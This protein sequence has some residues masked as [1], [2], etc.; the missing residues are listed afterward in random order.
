MPDISLQ[1]LRKSPDFTSLSPQNQQKVE[2]QYTKEAWEET[3]RSPN[4]VTGGEAARQKAR[5]VF[6][7][8]YPKAPATHA[9][10]D[11]AANTFFGNMVEMARQGALD[12]IDAVRSADDAMHGR[13]G[14]DLASRIARSE[15]R[16]QAAFT[17]ME[18]KEA[19]SHIAAESKAW[20]S[21]D[22]FAEKL[23]AAMDTTI[24]TG[25]EVLNNPK[26]VAYLFAK[27]SANMIPSMF[28]MAAGSAAGTGGSAVGSFAGSF[29]TEAGGYLMDQVSQEVYRRGLEPTEANILTVLEDPKFIAEASSKAQ[30]K[31]L[32]T[33]AVDAGL[34]FGVGRMGSATAR[35]AEQSAEQTLRNLA[36]GSKKVVAEIVSE[37]V[38]EAAGQLLAEGK[39]D[40][41][42]LMAETLGAIGGGAVI[43]APAHTAAYGKKTA[44]KALRPKTESEM[45]AQRMAKAP[46]AKGYKKTVETAVE[47]GEIDES[48]AKSNPIMA[49]EVK[50]KI[51]QKPDVSPVE[52]IRNQEQVQTIYDNLTEKKKVIL[53]EANELNAKKDTINEDEYAK[54]QSL[55]S[56]AKSVTKTIK[57][58]KPLL[59]SMQLGEVDTDETLTQVRDALK[60]DDSQAV[61][62]SII[63]LFG[64]RRSQDLQDLDTIL[65]NPQIS[66]ST[67]DQVRQVQAYQKAEEELIQVQDRGEGKRPEEVHSNIIDGGPGFKGTKTY[68]QAIGVA[69]KTGNTAVAQEQ[70]EGLKTFADRHAAKLE[71]ITAPGAVQANG[72]PHAPYFISLV[73][74]EVKTLQEAVTMA[75]SWMAPTPA[76]DT[77]SGTTAEETQVADVAPAEEAPVVDEK[78][79]TRSVDAEGVDTL[80]EETKTEEKTDA[81]KDQITQAADESVTED[82]ITQ[83]PKEPEA[84][85]E[86]VIQEPVSEEENEG[87]VAART[88]DVQDDQA[89]EE[90]VSSLQS[91]VTTPT[92]A[93]PDNH[94]KKTLAPKKG[95][96]G[97]IHK[98]DKIF[99]ALDEFATDDASTAM[100]SSIKEFGKDFHGHF[101]K[102]FK[103]KKNKAF[104]FEDPIQYL[105]DDNGKMP[106]AV[107]NTIMAV[108][109][110][111]LGTRASETVHNYDDDLRSI[112]GLDDEHPLNFLA[113]NLLGDIGVTATMLQESLGQEIFQLLGVKVTDDTEADFQNK[114]E[115]SLGLQA[116]ATLESMGYLEHTKVLKSDFDALI[117]SQKEADL[118]S[119]MAMAETFKRDPKAKDYREIKGVGTI[120][121]YKVLTADDKFDPELFTKVSEPQKEAKGLWSQ[122]FTGERDKRNYSWDAVAPKGD[123]L[124]KGTSFTASEKQMENIKNHMARPR[125]VSK[126]SMAIFLMMGEENLKKIQGWVDP[127]LTHVDDIET[128]EG[129]NAGIE[130]GNAFIDEWLA[131]AEAR[132]EG[133]ESEFYVPEEFWRQGR[134]GEVG[135]INMQGNKTHRFLFNLTEWERELDITDIDVQDQFMEAV[136]LGL[137][138][139]T[140][141][142]GGM[143]QTLAKARAEL[144]K[145]VLANAVAAAQRV[146]AFH[147]GLN[148]LHP[149]IMRDMVDDHKEDMALITEGAL[150]GGMG[151]HSVKTILEYA[152][153]LNA[154]AAGDKT[155]TTDLATEIDGVSNG[156][157]IGRTQLMGPGANMPETLTA[158]QN[159]GFAFSK[160]QPGLAEHLA[161][162]LSHDAYQAT[163]F[164]WTEALVNKEKELMDRIANA[165]TGR[166]K[167]IAQGEYVQ[168]EA[169]KHLLGEFRDED[170]HISK[171]VRKVS[172]DPTMRT[173]YG[174]GETALLVEL[175]NSVQEIIKKKITAIAQ[176]AN[177]EKALTDLRALAKDLKDLA[178]VHVFGSDAVTDGVVNPKVLLNTELPLDLLN[179][180]Q[181]NLADYHG[182]ALKEAITQ[183]YGPMQDSFKPLNK[184][185][186]LAAAAYNTIRK[187]KIRE[188]AKQGPITVGKMREIDA[189]L[190]G[191][192]PRVRTYLGGEIPLAK[193]SKEK[194]YSIRAKGVVN[195]EVKQ[196]YNDLPGKKA[197]PYKKEGLDA[198]GVAGTI[199]TIHNQD[200]M[201]AN[202][203]M[204][205]FPIL[206]NH[207]GFTIG[208]GQARDLSTH[209]CE[210]FFNVM[211]DYD[212]GMELH[213]GVE[214]V[215]AE[216]A[217]QQEVLKAAGVRQGFIDQAMVEQLKVMKIRSM[218]SPD[219]GKAKPISVANYQQAMKQIM[220]DMKEV[221]VV[222]KTNK[223]IIMDATVSVEQYS[224]PGG[225]YVTGNKAKTIKHNGQEYNPRT[226]TEEAEKRLTESMDNTNEVADAIGTLMVQENLDVAEVED[227]YTDEDLP[228]GDVFMSGPAKLSVDPVEYAIRQEVDSMN[229]MDVYDHIKNNSDVVD[230]AE[231]DTHLKG[232]LRDVVQN[233]LRPMDL[234]LK[235]NPDLE[236]EGAF[237]H[238]G[239]EKD[240]V[241]ITNQNRVIGP[242]SGAL[243]QGLRMSTG[244]VY[245]HELL[246]SVLHTGLSMNS[247]YKT[248]VEQLFKLAEKKIGA[249]HFLDDPTIDMTDPAY[250]YEVE[251]AQERYD[252]VFRNTDTLDSDRRSTHLDEFMVLALTN[253]NF[254]N[255]L[256]D[257]ELIGTEYTKHSWQGLIGKNIQETLNNIGQAIM[258]FFYRR[259]TAGSAR[260]TMADELRDLAVVIAKRDTDQ[261][262]AL[263]NSMVQLGKGSQRWSGYCNMFIKKALSKT[264]ILKV[265]HGL[266]T[267][268][269]M[270]HESDTLLGQR[271]REAEYA[272]RQLDQGIIKSLLAE[273]RGRTD[274]LAWLYDMLGRRQL[275]LDSAKEQET[276]RYINMAS[277]LFT[278]LKD[279]E[280][281]TQPITDYQKTVATKVGLKADLS[282][283]LNSLGSEGLR[284]V[285]EDS[286]EL[287]AQV[288][289]VLD[290]I[291]ADADLAPYEHYYRKAADALGHFMIHARGRR[292]EVVFQSTR[293][294]ASLANTQKAGSLDSTQVEKA[295]G[296]IDQLASLYALGYT[297]QDYRN[298][299]HE[300]LVQDP[301][302]VNGLLRMHEVL[303]DESL[304]QAFGG[305]KHKFIKGYTKQILNPRIGFRYGTWDDREILAREGYTI[306]PKAMARDNDDPTIATKFYVYT[307]KT[308]RVNDLMSTIASYTNNRAKGTDSARIARQMDITT[309]EG[310]ENNKTLVEAKQKTIDA[311][312]DPAYTPDLK[313]GN[314]MVPKVDNIGNVIGYRY[315]MAETT[316]DSFMEQVTAFDKILGAMA[317]QVVDKVR[318]PIINKELIQ[319]LEA[320]WSTE[321][322]SNPKGYVEISPNSTDSRLREIYYMLPESARKEVKRVWGSNSMMVSK[323]VVDLAFGYRQYSI[324]D[325]FTREP[326]ERAQLEKMVVAVAQMFFKDKAAQRMATVEALFTE[327]TKYAKN[328]IIVKS[329]YVTLGN[330][331]SNMIYLKSR[332][333]PV[334]KIL[335][336]GWEAIAMGNKYQADSKRL[337]QLKLRRD[338]VARGKHTP[339]QLKNLDSQIAR[340]QT[341]LKDNPTTRSIELG[342]MPSLVDDV[343]TVTSGENF[344]TDFEKKMTTLTGKLPETVQ[345][346]GKVVLLTEDTQAYKVLNNAVKMTDFIGRHV[347]YNHY[348]EGGMPNSEAVAAVSDEFI[349]FSVPTHRMIEYGNTIG[350]LWFTKYGS[351]VLKVIA[352]SVIDK[353]YDVFMAFMFSVHLGLDNIINSIPGVT[354]SLFSNLGDPVSSIVESADESLIID[355]ALSLF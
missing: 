286:A 47:A 42:E 335:K 234:Y 94:A 194:I 312:M 260:M 153:Y 12:T 313:P 205:A 49:A 4:Y 263:Y 271:M 297:A 109:Y 157:V 209:V 254:M 43:Q 108:A 120:S 159:G 82:Q 280:G 54:L 132:P 173:V 330:L 341:A 185:I 123:M 179:A 129:I 331:G 98:A 21:A 287:Q 124:L 289:K 299:F 277:D 18:L 197:A 225:Q 196:S 229:A 145:P 236:T 59:Q 200:S 110:K 198:P 216:F 231:H 152:R 127:M 131:E 92:E 240:R 38:S 195:Q 336:L 337:G 220:G 156:V 290:Q 206:N 7:T 36:Q 85:G 146:V 282:V 5:V 130:R 327:M 69:L 175:N 150:A 15:A 100:V 186:N 11:N 268:L 34:G 201:I 322:Q 259:L 116:I 66:D 344:P 178:G 44:K 318:S 293:V 248:K 328:N 29:S 24:A 33:A 215:L 121:F 10:E 160:A 218:P 106:P 52:K 338:I 343:E 199:L 13:H 241:F 163:G 111:W 281:N 192:F 101:T 37:P 250:Q 300:M 262:S 91:H 32:G 172:K 275:F 252:Y 114:M 270:A 222:T 27:S 345:K 267:T 169:M 302:G 355:S 228:E 320:M 298:A 161:R 1:E 65:E 226:I 238:L 184:G 9:Q 35:T 170:G 64:S 326:K 133:F 351:R 151:M 190:K 149:D 227:Y 232:V 316:K 19:E 285:L 75:T 3:T 348:L 315:M 154:L 350:L 103:V 148:E 243:S 354:K 77:V 81:Q 177:Q 143:E 39:V 257:I 53:A 182:A 276:E 105:L 325:A 125:K 28:G 304:A 147:Q 221:A 118:S 258:D 70:L 93:D 311:M 26:G 342:L 295:D 122:I 180:V 139:E 96:K 40:A 242:V 57:A 203:T 233:V 112:M 223:D 126:R 162:K 353:P 164:A 20:E 245:T 308:G 97:V 214:T 193:M 301:E 89:A 63:S 219:G 84:A 14:E 62:D 265:G 334:S 176:E 207:D 86:E 292:G 95:V 128:A 48:V 306:V 212:M 45:A 46:T 134:M 56:E 246:H 72:K 174:M 119:Y 17:P 269:T 323:D 8:L 68:T 137:D 51:N 230:D 71:S 291:K 104:R 255:A 16:R 60:S 171:T 22:T 202:T 274:R 314:F 339:A 136:A 78:G 158:L 237:V 340:L 140:T 6:D 88:E 210:T 309:Q 239:S 211:K 317:G 168:L 349:N 79:S 213:A 244:E 141:K 266:K 67:K 107:T 61:S 23:S 73:K 2:T 283:L 279:E 264:P 187:I 273:V 167:L 191:L 347:L 188:A 50:Q 352:E 31:A 58:V 74:A 25:K 138:I 278:T 217:K 305:N 142:E 333:V 272:Y 181:T 247:L 99:N 208:A 307:S 319:G 284:A 324:V 346:V 90:T 332:G 102:Q 115:L 303:K 166:E 83:E 329:L 253:K 294:I 249:Q 310:I 135:D 224:Y 117:A 87:E 80:I 256:K 55:M 76:A 144:A 189:S 321:G 251:A 296:L 113:H 165:S 261:K 155:F 235:D 288:N 204:G 41:G 183:V 30:R